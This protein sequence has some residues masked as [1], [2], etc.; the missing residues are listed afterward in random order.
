M[1]EREDT[2]AIVVGASRGSAVGVSSK[3]AARRGPKWPRCLGGTPR[4]SFAQRAGALT[5][6]VPMPRTLQSLR[7][8]RQTVSISNPRPVQQAFFYALPQA[9]GGRGII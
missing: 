7:G 1:S 2:K 8:I 5:R 9:T 3:G 4:T 6:L